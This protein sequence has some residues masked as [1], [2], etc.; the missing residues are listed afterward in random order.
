MDNMITSVNS[1]GLSD[2][3]YLFTIK[4]CVL[5]RDD[6]EWSTVIK[7]HRSYSMNNK[8]N[9]CITGRKDVFTASIWWQD[10]SSPSWGVSKE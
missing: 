2:L 4:T 7:D 8:V 9:W 6:D 3:F 10:A 5:V 1:M